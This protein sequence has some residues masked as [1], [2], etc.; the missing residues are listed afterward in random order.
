[1]DKPLIIPFFIPH[2]GCPFTC[3]FC[4]QWEISGASTIA[5]PEDIRPRVMSYLAAHKKESVRSEVAFYGG[6]FTG[7]EQ[8]LQDGLLQAAHA[9]KQEGLIQGI[10]LST[11]PDY[12]NHEIIRNLVTYGVT[13]VELGVQSLVDEVLI[14]SCRGNSYLDVAEATQIIRQYPLELVFQLMIGLPGDTRARALL[15][16][17]RVIQLIPDGLRIYPTL[18][19]KGTVLANWYQQGLYQPWSLEEAVELGA[20]WLGIFSAY[21]IKVI[22][23]G[24]QAADNL[25]PEVDLVAGPYHPAYGELVQSRLMLEQL[26]CIIENLSDKSGPLTI[27]CHPRDYSKVTGQKGINI[28]KLR[29]TYHFA[30]IE[31]KGDPN[32]ALMDLRIETQYETRTLARQEFLKK[33]RIK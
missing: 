23:L 32:I 20:E 21:G 26:S 31:I 1:M 6:S 22:R 9:L 29:Q 11:R 2:A 16:A 13:A 12:I 18:V 19:M 4:N 30:E 8:Q 10:R 17:Q 24:L 28:K 3:V 25:S 14:K 33:Y 27:Y 7:I 5:Q 15:T